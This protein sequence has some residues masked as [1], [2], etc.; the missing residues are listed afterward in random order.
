MSKGTSLGMIEVRGLLGAVVAADAGVKAAWVHVNDMVRIRG[1][2]VTVMFTG[3]VAAV[4][5]AV[6]AGLTAIQ[7]F[8]CLIDHYV[9][10]RVD[11][12][13]EKLKTMDRLHNVKKLPS[14][15]KEDKKVLPK[16]LSEVNIV[17]KSANLL[18]T[19]SEENKQTSENNNKEDAAQ[20]SSTTGNE[21]SESNKQDIDYVVIRRKLERQRV[22]DLKKR[23]YQMNLVI[24]NKS[25]KT[26][27]KRQLVAA[28]MRQITRRD[29]K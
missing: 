16:K 18:I 9:I 17:A 1:G 12:Q 20:N 11:E 7:D 26:A 10:A 15:P 5:A 29:D 14:Q 28:I 25:I 2:L 21:I 22:S 3:D 13:T 23:A 6:A 27:T 8:N 4:N 19:T 24:P